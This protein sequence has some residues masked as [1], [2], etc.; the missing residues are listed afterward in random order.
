MKTKVQTLLQNGKV[1]NHRGFVDAETWIV[2]KIDFL[3]N[4]YKFDDCD[5]ERTGDVFTVRCHRDPGKPGTR[6]GRKDII[7]VITLVN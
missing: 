3:K 7:F 4:I 2:R 5:V 1:I 6:G